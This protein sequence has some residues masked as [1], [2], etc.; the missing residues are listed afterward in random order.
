MYPVRQKVRGSKTSTAGR[1]AECQSERIMPGSVVR[2]MLVAGILRPLYAETSFA[3]VLIVICVSV[4]LFTSTAVAASSINVPLDDWSYDALE[5]LA[6]FGLL[7]SDLKGTK[8]YPRSE[9]ARLVLEALYAK[10]QDPN[11]IP[12]LAE[13]FLQRFQKEYRNEL[14]LLDWGEGNTTG[15]FLKPINEA[16]IRYVYSD[17][18]PTLFRGFPNNPTGI[19]AGEG[20][21]LVYNNEGVIYGEHHNA[22]IQFSSSMQFL[23]IFSGYLE[24]LFLARQNE[25]NLKGIEGA[26]VDLLKGYVKVSPWNIEFEAGRDSLWWGQGHH[27]TLLLSDNATPLDMMKLSNPVPFLLPWIFRY[28]GP[29]KYAFVLARLEENRD[30]PHASLGGMRLDLKPFPNFEMGMIHTF[31]FGGRGQPGGGFGD[32]LELLSFSKSGGG[33]SDNTDQLTAFDFKFR[34]PRLRNTEIYL[35]WGGENPGFDSDLKGF[36]FQDPGYIIGIYVPRLTDDG[37]TDF[38]IEYADNVSERDTGYWYGHT[39]YTS[40]YTY[41]GMILGH[42]MGPDARDVY[43]RITRYF[44]HDLLVGLD[45]DYT[46]FGRGLS[47]VVEQEYQVGLDASFDLT[48]RIR[49]KSRFG[50][51]AVNNFNLVGSDSRQN[52]L[53]A[54]ELS[55]RF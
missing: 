53:F 10:Q 40:G 13:Y 43:A 20:T 19:N 6:G 14:A 29:L 30:R 41:E 45:F 17:G 54:T 50:Y 32:Y 38:R 39:R 15:T 48:D 28:L 18:K 52:N 4:A 27:G 34:I 51:G 22:S 21:P 42:H 36:P 7:S 55:W 47:P 24:P 35:E 16:K 2:K 37:L 1:G 5:K 23:G 31:L 49:A 9:V 8:P 26:E 3:T 25:G 33:S 11:G 44:R 12:A 46:E